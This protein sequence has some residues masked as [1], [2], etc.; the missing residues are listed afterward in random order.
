MFFI[1][2]RRA[3]CI[4]AIVAF[5]LIGQCCHAQDKKDKL[6]PD[7]LLAR[8]RYREI[9][10]GK[11]AH[12]QALWAFAQYHLAPSGKVYEAAL[13][14]H[15]KGA[16]LG[17]FVAW[18]CQK[19]GI[20][21]RRDEK[22]MWR[23]H[24]EVRSRLEKKKEHTP[25]ELYLLAHVDPVDS[26]GVLKLPE[27]TKL[28]DF[29]SK[30]KKLKADR[31]E[32][33]ATAGFAEACDKLGKE[34]QESEEFDKALQWHD[35]AIELGHAGSMRSKGYLLMVGRGADKD[36]K[37]AYALALRAA[38]RGD[39]FAMINVAVYSDRGWGIEADK[40]KA[41]QWLA[42]A[43]ESGHWAG[44]IEKGMAHYMGAY[45]Y[46]M[47][48]KAG[49]REWRAAHALRIREVLDFLARFHAEGTGVSKDG[50]RAAHFAEAAFVQGSPRAARML[51]YL[52][53]E[54]IGGLEKNEKLKEY[55]SIQ[56]NPNFAFTFGE[57][58]E[59]MQPE[60]TKRLKQL[61]PWAWE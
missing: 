52:H 26:D 51:A 34:F 46:E 44:P 42:K 58:L 23:L 4:E 55:W 61:D 33:A 7:E 28:A 27:N 37:A 38:E 32:R 48:A 56:A 20:G 12:G 54:G 17:A 16:V 9:P 13:E 50:K 19:E 25:L 11:D 53:G 43:A 36:A 18:Q 30:N 39:A 8:G 60:L 59:K 57:A 49:E 10:A 3:I 47:D 35:K 15:Q 40:K 1:P 29:E 41:Q 45:G 22:L 31:L 2:L 5:L 14:A 21:V 24:F 6:K